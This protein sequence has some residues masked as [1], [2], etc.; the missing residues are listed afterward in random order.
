MRFTVLA[1]AALLSACLG[2][3]GSEVIKPP[4]MTPSPNPAPMM[5]PPIVA[6]GIPPQPHCPCD[7]LRDQQ[8]IRATVLGVESFPELTNLRRYALRADEILSDADSGAP[9]LQ[10]GD[11]F[12]G[13]WQGELACGGELQ[14]AIAVG[15]QVLAFYRRGWQDGQLCCEYIA[16]SDD[17]PAEQESDGDENPANSPQE[18][19]LQQCRTETA[20]A[21]AQHSEEAVMHGDLM[22][23]PWGDEFV[24]GVSEHGQATIAEADLHALTLDR[25]ACMGALDDRFDALHPQEPA[26]QDIDEGDD[27][28]TP[29]PPAP[30]TPPGQSPPAPM[31]TPMTMPLPPAPSATPPPGTNTAV[32]PVGP[33]PA[34][35]EELR[36]RCQ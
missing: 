14:P 34:H 20:D 12:G 13:Y 3:S 11:R 5:H 2:Q 8:Q 19:C 36:V 6:P 22:L 31:S 9:S 17:C 21:C 7:G 26:S 27:Q 24:V 30:A 32:A 10:P 35:P 33:P 25:D 18:R 29:P 23:M 16:C 15:T 1:S 28:A 4:T